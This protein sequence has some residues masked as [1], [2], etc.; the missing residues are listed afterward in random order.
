[1]VCSMDD[2]TLITCSYNTPEVTLTMLR[3]FV[4][5]HGRLIRV[6]V[7]ENSSDDKTE[8][9]LRKDGVPYFRNPKGMHAPSIDLLFER[10]ETRYALLVDTDII[11][12]KNH[13]RPHEY[14]K[15]RGLTLMGEV[16]GDRGGKLIYDR[17]HP[18][19]CFIDVDAIR[20]N[21][22]RF[23]DP[24]RYTT[25][26]PGEGE[27]N[28]DVGCSFYE[29]ILCCGLKV[30]DKRMRNRY[31]KH[32]EGMS[33]RYQRFDK[34]CSNTDGPIDADADSRHSNEILYKLGLK[35]RKAY[36]AEIKK[37]NSI[38]LHANIPAWQAA[39][40]QYG[41]NMRSMFRSIICR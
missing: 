37:Y 14:F 28:Y 4:A 8:M 9:L 33:W 23:F 32:Y 2:L 40:M 26:K 15:R 13:S 11:F 16:C 12:L 27:K 3:S 41:R 22:L 1:M 17:V 5:V 6:L 10:V 25:R 20:H 35:V 39:A 21:G 24:E 31:F 38:S 34:K 18:W 30:R 19:H 7:C 36:D 29:D